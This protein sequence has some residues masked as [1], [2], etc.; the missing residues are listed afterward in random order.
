MIGATP[1]R[2]YAMDLQTFPKDAS[3]AWRSTGG[4][5]VWGEVRRRTLDRAGSYTRRLLV[6]TDLARLVSLPT[7]VLGT[8]SRVKLLSWMRSQYRPLEDLSA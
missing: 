2:K 3:I 7:P 6:E 5:G 1:L 4:K 8:V